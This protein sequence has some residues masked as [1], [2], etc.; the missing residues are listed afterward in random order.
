MDSA[1]EF[2][3]A[4]TEARYQ[5]QLHAKPNET[6]EEKSEEKPFDPP[7]PKLTPEQKAT[8]DA[9]EQRLANERAEYDRQ[10]AKIIMAGLK[11]LDNAGLNEGARDEDERVRE[12]NKKD[13]ANRAA[14]AEEGV[15]FRGLGSG[16]PIAASAKTS[17]FAAV[18]SMFQNDAAG[19]AE[20]A[21]ARRAEAAAAKSARR[22]KRRAN[23]LFVFSFRLFCFVCLRVCLFV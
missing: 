7:P 8:Q 15:A 3:D 19:A 5:A 4:E 11:K 17:A 13:R 18:S 14:A 6:K 2:Y 23:I 21:G 22:R 16:A 10:Q 20:G 1:D 9:E 12:F